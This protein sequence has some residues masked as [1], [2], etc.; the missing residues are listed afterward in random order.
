M[1]AELAAS[2]AVAATG[3]VSDIDLPF[4][5]MNSFSEIDQGLLTIFDYVG[6]WLCFSCANYP[7]IT[8]Q[9]SAS[10]TLVM[11]VVGTQKL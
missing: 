2:A 7:D 11:G 5:V 9:S 6:T 3:N 10:E 1:A 4:F 8:E